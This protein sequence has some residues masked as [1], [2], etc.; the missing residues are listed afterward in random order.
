MEA[1]D[2]ALEH[3]L[4][5]Q[6]HRAPC[7]DPQVLG[8]FHLGTLQVGRE[9]VQVHL[10]ICSRC[11]EELATL[12]RFLRIRDRPDVRVL[13][14][15]AWSAL[16]AAEL[17]PAYAVRGGPQMTSAT[18]RAGE[19]TL[20]V[21]MTE[22]PQDRSLRTL[23]GILTSDLGVPPARARLIGS[24]YQGEAS[25]DPVGQ[26]AFDSVPPGRYTLEV[27]AGETVMQVYPL[28]VG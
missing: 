2:E 15:Q 23:A 28:E 11:R 16:R 26:F 9:E 17:S 3:A 1:H 21:S 19:L 25:V 24:A 12:E 4:A 5:K 14:A 8:D 27:E 18:Y 20:T 10:E 22:D 13:L 7:P 6:L